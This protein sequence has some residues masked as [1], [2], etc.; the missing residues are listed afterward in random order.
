MYVVYLFSPVQI[1][2]QTF[3]CVFEKPPI[4]I[5][6]C[7]HQAR[8]FLQALIPEN[9]AKE[10]HKVDK[11]VVPN[12]EYGLLIYNSVTPKSVTCQ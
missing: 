12:Q 7:L 11:Q 4:T 3:D 1:L 6:I 9:A 5:F 10:T 2:L 8:I